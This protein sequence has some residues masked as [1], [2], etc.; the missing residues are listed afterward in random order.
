MASASLQWHYPGYEAPV[1]VQHF[2]EGDDTV[3]K[4]RQDNRRPF[5]FCPCLLR[6][7]AQDRVWAECQGLKRNRLSFVQR[8]H[9]SVKDSAT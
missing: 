1:L 3:G 8:P 5:S 7:K 2:C 4:E 6:S 9:C